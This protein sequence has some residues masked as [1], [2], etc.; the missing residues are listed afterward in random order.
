MEKK[1]KGSDGFLLK[2]EELG[3]WLKVKEVVEWRGECG[4]GGA[5]LGGG[6]GATVV[7]VEAAVEWVGLV[8]GLVEN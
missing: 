4:D 3:W 6:G 7:M 2:I 1:W 8:V 5:G